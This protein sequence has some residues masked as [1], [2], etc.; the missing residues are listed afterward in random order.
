MLFSP[1]IPAFFP[2]FSILCSLKSSCFLNTY[3]LGPSSL[4]RTPELSWSMSGLE[5]NF[6]TLDR[7]RGK[8]SLL[9]WETLLEQ[10][11]S[12]RENWHWTGVLTPLLYPG[13]KEWDGVLQVICWL[14]EACI[15]DGRKSKAN[16]FS[17][18]GRSGDRYTAQEGLKSIKSY[19]LEEGRT[20]VWFFCFCIPRPSLV[21]SA[22]SSL[23]HHRSVN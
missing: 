6:Q 2:T 19:N 16:T 4:L 9:E 18:W 8:Q 14:D 20:R 5:K 7:M 10:Q 13:Y 17:L 11:A 3:V 23:G 22:L 21:L 15:L 1:L 12:S